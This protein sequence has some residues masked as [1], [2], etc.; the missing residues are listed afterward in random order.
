MLLSM[1]SLLNSM[2][3][4]MT[5]QL[6]LGSTVSCQQSIRHWKRLFDKIRTSGYFY[7]IKHTNFL[8]LNLKDKL[9]L[10]RFFIQIS[11]ALKAQINEEKQ[12]GRPSHESWPALHGNKISWSYEKRISLQKLK[13]LKWKYHLLRRKY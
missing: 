10:S 1:M 6:A 11:L 13:V 7:M 4:E 2:L 9:L 5:L 3:Q 12:P 8:V